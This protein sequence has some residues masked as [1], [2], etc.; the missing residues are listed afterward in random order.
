MDEGKQ[1][2]G[3][4][5]FLIVRDEKGGI[6]EL[7]GDFY[8]TSDPMIQGAII[9]SKKEQWNLDYAKKH[10]ASAKLIAPIDHLGPTASSPQDEGG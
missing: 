9:M 8:R 2:T 7:R 6:E 3:F 10:Q 1:I 5:Q 4:C